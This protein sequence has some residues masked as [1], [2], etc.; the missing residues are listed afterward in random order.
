MDGGY[1]DREPLTLSNSDIDSD[2]YWSHSLFSFRVISLAVA[3]SRRNQERHR[4]GEHPCLRV[5][6][7]SPN[8]CGFPLNFPRDLLH[9]V[10]Q[11]VLVPLEL[12]PLR[13]AKSSSCRYS[14]SSSSAS[15]D[16]F[17]SS[18]IDSMS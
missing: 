7:T 18:R 13:V 14:G 8:C 2:E 5:S 17:N 10:T 9:P 11:E 15:I 4:H 3:R 1:R 12:I 16:R 6:K